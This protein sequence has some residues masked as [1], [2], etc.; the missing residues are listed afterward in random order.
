ME[1]KLHNEQIAHDLAIALCSKAF[2]A[3]SFPN[4]TDNINAFV[5]EYFTIYDKVL[6]SVSR[7]R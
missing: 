3:D 2:P 6:K 1:F 4:G 5:Q 7:E